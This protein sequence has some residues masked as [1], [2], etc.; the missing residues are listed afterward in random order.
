[1]LG[2]A[3]KSPT[4]RGIVDVP[5]RVERIKQYVDQ[6]AY[7]PERL[8]DL[9]DRSELQRLVAIRAQLTQV[10]EEVQSLID[11]FRERTGYK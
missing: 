5:G 6:F 1:M 7:Q 11:D 2:R 8:D 3:P 9:L 4:S 10:R